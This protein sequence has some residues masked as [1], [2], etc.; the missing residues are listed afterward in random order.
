MNRKSKTIKQRKFIANYLNLIRE[1]SCN[2]WLKLFCLLF[3]VCGALV[4]ARGQ[5][6]AV[7]VR[8]FMGASEETRQSAAKGRDFIRREL[9]RIKREQQLPPMTG[10]V[11]IVLH[12]LFRNHGS[13]DEFAEYLQQHSQRTVLSFGYASTRSNVDTHAARLAGVIEHLQKNAALDI[14][15]TRRR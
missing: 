1:N 5:V 11:V 3:I 8:P 9:E 6:R 10:K 4:E 2:S 7:W 13:M 14:R 12:G 15:F